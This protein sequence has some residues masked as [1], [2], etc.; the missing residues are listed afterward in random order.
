MYGD[1]ITQALILDHGYTALY[2]QEAAK[3]TLTTSKFHKTL[4]QIT[5]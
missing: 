1:E 2:R 5:A 3:A 4:K